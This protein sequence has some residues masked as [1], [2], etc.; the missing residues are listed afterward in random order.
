MDCAAVA[1]NAGSA[2]L[3]PH[4]VAEHRPVKI[5]SFLTELL[6]QHSTALPT[7]HCK[8]VPL[9]AVKIILSKQSGK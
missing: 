8:K 6:A 5:G 7:T 4:V 9:H 3:S 2:M 1:T